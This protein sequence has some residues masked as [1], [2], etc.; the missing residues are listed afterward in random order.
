MARDGDELLLNME[1]FRNAQERVENA[2]RLFVADLRN[3]VVFLAKRTQ[4]QIDEV[5]DA[6]PCWD[7]RH[8]GAKFQNIQFFFSEVL[9]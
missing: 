6:F 8:E 5:A 2:K 3:A 7:F 1:S 9:K 4:I